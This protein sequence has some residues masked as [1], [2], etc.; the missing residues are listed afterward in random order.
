MLAPIKLSKG[1]RSTPFQDRHRISFGL[2]I[3]ELD[4]ATKNVV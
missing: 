4:P 1:T 3:C 2:K